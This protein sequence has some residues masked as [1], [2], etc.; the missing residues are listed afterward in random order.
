LFALMCSYIVT[1]GIITRFEGALSA[2][3]CLVAYMPML[4]GTGGNS[5]SQ[6]A[7]LII[8]GL[9]VGELSVRDTLRILWKEFRVSIIIGFL[10]QGVLL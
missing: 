2:M 1:G 6:S 10:L 7:T 5:G 3:I 9:A 8:R 4:S